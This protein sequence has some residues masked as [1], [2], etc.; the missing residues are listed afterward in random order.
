MGMIITIKSKEKELVDFKLDY[1]NISC[2]D[3]LLNI[4][5]T[6]VISNEYEWNDE[7]TTTG[8]CLKES[9]KKVSYINELLTDLNDEVIYKV[10]V[11]C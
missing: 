11:S 2:F 5:Q 9:F 1:K 6:K 10:E 7:I 3:G 8:K 4:G